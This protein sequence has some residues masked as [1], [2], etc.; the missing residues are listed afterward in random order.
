MNRGAPA[1]LAAALALWV[2]AGAAAAPQHEHHQSLPAPVAPQPQAPEVV[3]LEVPD[4]PVLDQE[5]R[6]LRFT[7]SSSRAGSSP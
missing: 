1:A 5:G 6:P 3:G 7:P 4:V 2:A